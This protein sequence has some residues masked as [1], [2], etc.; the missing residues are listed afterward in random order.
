MRK[1]NIKK[2]IGIIA[3]AGILMIG[4]T[5][6]YFTD[7]DSA[8]NII[9]L[10]HVDIDITEEMKDP[11]HPEGITV[12]YKDPENVYPGDR[13]SKIPRIHLKTDSLAS[14]VRVVVT[15]TN[16]QSAKPPVTIDDINIDDANWLVLPDQASENVWYCYYIGGEQEGLIQPGET[17]EV[18]SE[19][20]IP[21]DWGTEINA[22]EV[23][24]HILAEAVQAEGFQPAY[25]KEKGKITSV[26]W[27]GEDKKEVRT[28]KFEVKEK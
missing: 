11:E 9:R 13:I 10:G 17:A 20:K 14:Y 21:D 27:I 25:E 22:S 16:P 7:K 26:S 4:A 28:E 1:K 24:V 19:V 23:K 15:I 6:A 18:F 3:L 5:F 8:M 2:G 12:P